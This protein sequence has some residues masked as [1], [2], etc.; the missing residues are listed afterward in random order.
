VAGLRSILAGSWDG[1]ALLRAGLAIA[2]TG[3]VAQ[4]LAM[5]A[6]AARTARR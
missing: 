6:L 2:I 1:G 5:K 4:S 3:V